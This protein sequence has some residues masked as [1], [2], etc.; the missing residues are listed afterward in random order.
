MMQRDA[1]MRKKYTKPKKYPL[2]ALPVFEEEK[3]EDMGED[4]DDPNGAAQQHNGL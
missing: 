3:D 2:A 1:K 4:E